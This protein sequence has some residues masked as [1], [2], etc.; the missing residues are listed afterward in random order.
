MHRVAGIKERQDHRLKKSGW[1]HSQNVFSGTIHF[2]LPANNFVKKSLINASFEPSGG[3]SCLFLSLASFSFF[4]S[5]VSVY[6]Y[7]HAENATVL[8]RFLSILTISITVQNLITMDGWMD[9][10]VE[11]LT[12]S[13]RRRL[14]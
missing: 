4:C 7:C 9:E 5:S 6:G 8:L 1:L 11:N 12:L 14:L 10:G 2:F 3:S 13:H